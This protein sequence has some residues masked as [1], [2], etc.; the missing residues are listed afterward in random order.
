MR[1][2]VYA[3]RICLMCSLLIMANSIFLPA[4]QPYP[5]PSFRNFGTNDGLP[6]PEVYCVMQD[7]RGYMWFGTDNGV[8]RFNGY[9]FTNFGPANGLQSNVVFN[10]VED[11]RNRI[12]FGTMS[13]ELFIFEN[14]TIIPY[15][16]NKLILNYRNQYRIGN[17]LHVSNEQQVTLSLLG[18][19]ILQIDARGVTLLHTTKTLH[20]GVILRAGSNIFGAPVGKFLEANY[21][22]EAQLHSAKY[23]IP[24]EIHEGSKVYNVELSSARNVNEPFRMVNINERNFFIQGYGNLYKI[25]NNKVVEFRAF[26][27]NI[28][29]AIQLKNGN[30]VLCI[31]KGGGMRMY[32]S[33]NAI[34]E[35]RYEQLL[36]GLTITDV[37]VDNTG[38]I[39]I[40]SLGNGIFYCNDIEINVWDKNSGIESD[41]V[42]SIGFISNEK[43][44]IGYGNGLVS[45]LETVRERIT[46]YGFDQK[47]DVGYT[48]NLICDNDSG[49]IWRNGEYLG[50]GRW[51]SPKPTNSTV[52]SNISLTSVYSSPDR[53]YF[54]GGG[55][56]GFYK[57]DFKSRSVLLNSL[58]DF[59]IADRIFSIHE[60]KCG[61]LWVGLQT[62]IAQFINGRLLPAHVN[63][64]AF[65]V[66]VESIAETSDSTL[67]FGTKG[68]GVVFWKD[69]KI[70]NIREKDGL[71]SNMIENIHVDEND[72][73]WVATLSGLNKITL[74]A[75]DTPVIRAITIA[76]GL[77]SNEIYQTASL[78]GQVWLAT[79]GGLVKYHEQPPAK[80]A[81]P[82]FFTNLQVNAQNVAFTQHTFPYYQNNIK[83]TYLNIN[84]CLLGKIHYRYRLNTLNPWIE[85]YSTSVNLPALKAGNYDFEVQA[86]NGD[87]LWSAAATYE[88][89]ILP[90]WWER[91]PFRIAAL[92]ALLMIATAGYR[93]RIQQL[94]RKN[95]IQQ[96]IYELEGKAL[97]AQMNPHFLFNCLNSIKELISKNETEKALDYLHKFAK[98]VRSNLM[99]SRRGEIVLSDEIE[100]LSGYLNL[101]KMRF[102]DLFDFTIDVDPQIDVYDC[103]LPPMLVQPFVENAVIHAFKNRKDKGH[104]WIR[105]AQNAQ[106]LVISVTDNGVGLHTKN[107]EEKVTTP[108]VSQGIA[109]VKDRLALIN[110]KKEENCVIL[111]EIVNTD[112][113]IGG[114]E[115]RIFLTS[116]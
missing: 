85:T 112:G 66:R 96:K 57:I 51:N 75:N 108:H 33:A 68:L 86:Q 104:I 59:K 32:K 105:F 27:S 106:G 34:F 90:P 58:M 72:I 46:T 111:H 80:V 69:N 107:K 53:N 23:M 4:Q 81:T 83:I 18:L 21:W 30:F 48:Y 61:N 98:L 78:N 13:G 12:W 77:P 114:T 8:S 79:G 76:Q 109:L 29:N 19:G 41:F 45:M 113:T 38:A 22:A 93:N 94:R 71:T 25:E 42:S 102:K 52:F 47:S 26:S 11:N 97:Q 55:G 95:E 49:I 67:V 82:P 99:V 16:Y 28:L 116:E 84:Y 20:G 63:H 10:I 40:S 36:E 62:G 60:D 100:M 88:F 91:W 43:V 101:E 110:G 1:E 103:F 6:S 24:F 7:H 37:F 14:D 65:Q 73:I 2:M 17:L 44:L 3:T 89:S 15:Q 50:N 35:D 115:V 5:H 9:T 92:T 74:S 87:N 54:W 64:P 39:W 31:D 70:V 56:F